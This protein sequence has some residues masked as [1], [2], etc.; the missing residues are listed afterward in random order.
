MTTKE[1][2]LS[3]LR[4]SQDFV[5]GE[6]L[7]RACS[8]S[9]TAVWKAIRSL[10]DEGYKI[11]A[12][13]NRGYRILEEPDRLDAR[14]LEAYLA[15][16][17]VRGVKAF[18]FSEIDSTNSEAKR[19]AV[20]AGSF[21]NERGELTPSGEAAHLSLFAAESQSG[22]KG[23]LGRTFVSPAD[24][25]VYFSLLYSP[26]GGVQNP[27][28]YTAAA[29]VAVSRAIA[30]LYG[31][32]A[33]I[34]WVNDVFLGEKKVS[35]ILVE[36]IAGF[37][38]GTVDA[39]VVG[40]G[41]NVRDAQLSGEIANIVGSIEEA[42]R[43]RGEPFV[44]RTKNELVGEVVRNLVAFYDAFDRGESAEKDAMIREYRERSLLIGKKVTVNP[45][46][47]S[48]FKSYPAVVKEISEQITLIVECD[49]GERRELSSGEVSLHSYDF[50]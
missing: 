27:A 43:V 11:E 3:A 26:R 50:V 7:A 46:A 6:S 32:E 45:V 28:L 34:K 44:A 20:E 29:A 42:K 9:R 15:E 5:S 35:G 48:D 39:A 10:E 8:V 17:G 22:G 33:R 38:T 19:R 24:V 14:T 37:E 47:G 25:G 1:N 23:R 21:R 12:V 18:C 13:T 16:R 4:A 41:I 2:I 36:G 30:A 40:I 31:E 49:G